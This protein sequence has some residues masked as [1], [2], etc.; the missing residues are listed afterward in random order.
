CTRPIPTPG[1]GGR[2]CCCG[3]AP[4]RPSCTWR[5]RSS[6][7]A[8]G[9]REEPLLSL[10]RPQGLLDVLILA[11][12][13]WGLIAGL[14]LGLARAAASLVGLAAGWA[15]AALLTGQALAAADARWDV[16]GSLAA[17]LD[18]AAAPASAGPA[19]VDT[20]REHLAHRLADGA[21]AGGSLGE[22]L[23]WGIASALTFVVLFALTRLAFALLGRIL[24]TVFD[25][26]PLR[27]LNRLA[28]AAFT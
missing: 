27:L 6:R 3:S 24:H 2:S 5:P 7:D 1:S 13:A 17:A 9:E 10:P 18:R 14:R 11:F 15:V 25:A 22:L 19:V 23:A 28:G 20:Y 16:V 21:G 4:A 12:L 26:G 8:V